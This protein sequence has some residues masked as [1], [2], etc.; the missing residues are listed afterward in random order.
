MSELQQL[1]LLNLSDDI[2][3]VISEFC[4]LPTRCAVTRTNSALKSVFLGSVTLT[5]FMSEKFLKH[6]LFRRRI[7]T[8]VLLPSSN[9]HLQ[10]KIKKFTDSEIDILS[11][12]G[13]VFLYADDDELIS[14]WASQLFR[15]KTCIK[16]NLAMHPV[17]DLSALAGLKNL[18]H[19][20]LRKTLVSDISVL[21]GLTN[22]TYL[23]LY[24]TKVS[25]LSVLAGLT[26]LTHLDL[27]STRISDISVLAGL[28]KLTYLD[29]Y[30][31][32]VSDVSALAGHKDMF[33]LTLRDTRVSDLS[34]LA[35]LKKLTYLDVCHSL[36]S[37]MSPVAGLPDLNLSR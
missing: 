17:S 11:S 25:D 10:V 13:S 20:D 2:L 14:A 21:A 15:I 18:T 16:L 28:T 23:D 4:D 12:V 27:T 9:L 32:K 30:G 24:F 31:T 37:D 35:G 1:V 36:V 22:L 19:L 3:Q 8:R 26:N 7:C 33:Y 5:E 34:A 6:D 29:L